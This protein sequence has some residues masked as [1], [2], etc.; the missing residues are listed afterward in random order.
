MDGRKRVWCS[1]SCKRTFA[2]ETQLVNDVATF[3]RTCREC[4]IQKV[5]AVDF[6]PTSAGG[7]RRNCRA[8][9]MKGNTARSAKPDAADKKRNAHLMGLYG[10]SSA[11][12]EELLQSQGG[13]CAVCGKPPVRQRLS[14]DHDHRSM[15][16]RGL[17]CNYCNL[18]IIGKHTDARLYKAAAD[19][20]ENPP[21][22]KLLPEHV[23]PHRPARRRKTRRKRTH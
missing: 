22:A 16:I 2:T 20:L 18:R 17:L 3:V 4:G 12:Y 5:L 23:V 19:Y 15:F 14:V 13:V 7:Y 8:C 21:A 9:V 10:I 11:Q 6:Y 1:L